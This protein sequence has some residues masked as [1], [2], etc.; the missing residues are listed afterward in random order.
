MGCNVR[1][2][3]SKDSRRR[4]FYEMLRMDGLPRTEERKDACYCGLPL[5]HVPDRIRSVLFQEHNKIKEAIQK[6]GITAYDP[7]DAPFNPQ[8]SRTDPPEKV[9]TTDILKLAECGFFTFTNMVSSTG[10]GIEQAKAHSLVKPVIVF[11]K[12]SKDSG[13]YVSRMSTGMTRTFV[14]EYSDVEKVSSSITKLFRT[15]KSYEFGVGN[16]TIHGNVLTGFRQKEKVCLKG[17]FEEK[18]PEL[19]YR[20]EKYRR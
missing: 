6:A 2:I 20:F 9:Y 8:L 18:F 15:L 14:V 7:A 10:S 5:S 4:Y 13:F 12:G 11:V 16:C 19:Q 3:L 1:V 17:L